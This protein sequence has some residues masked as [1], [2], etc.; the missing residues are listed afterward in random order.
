V[1]VGDP[2]ILFHDTC[3]RQFISTCVEHGTYLGCPC[4]LFPAQGAGERAE[5]SQPR[6]AYRALTASHS[7]EP[8]GMV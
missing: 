7:L 2:F 3:W 4:D 5:D 6:D 1:Q 8:T